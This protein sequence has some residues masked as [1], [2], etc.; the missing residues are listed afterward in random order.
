MGRD[1]DLAQHADRRPGS[2]H[3]GCHARGHGRRAG[4]P[5]RNRAPR[6][7]GTS[8]RG[9]VPA[10]RDD[11]QHD[12]QA[13][14]RVCFG[15]DAGGAR[16]RHRR[17]ARGPGSGAGSERCLEGP[18]RERQPDGEQPD[19]P[20]AQHLRRHR[21]RRER[22]LLAQDHGRRARRDPAAQ[23]GHQ[24]DGRPAALVRVRSDARC[25]RGRNRGTSRRAGGG[26]RRRGHLE[27]PDRQREPARGELDYAG[28][29]HRRGDDR[30]RARR[31]VAQDH[32]RCVRRSA[33]AQEHDQHDGRPVE[34]VR[35]GSDAGGARGGDR[36]QARRPGAGARRGRHVEGPD[37]QRQLHGEQPD[38]PGAQHRRSGDRHRQWRPVE[39]DHGQRE[40]R[41][42][43]AQGNA[44]HD[45]RAA[46]CLRLRGDPRRTRSRHR[47]PA[48][49]PGAG[50]R[51]RRAPGR[52]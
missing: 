34:R 16:G 39:E 2:S 38:R 10:L 13:A 42:P 40:R 46:P 32:R 11:R 49:R 22:R 4:Q 31:P 25:A 21:R 17:Q 9:R 52:T 15:S 5:A 48:R 3:D 20:G 37:R 51:R 1:A 47:R 33:R 41:D 45:G 7:R 43:A 28:P 8:A 19:G 44:Q 29:Q 14:L 6:R 18:D 12:D 26:A 36:R 24:H 27:G 23:G 50:A 30:R 35:V